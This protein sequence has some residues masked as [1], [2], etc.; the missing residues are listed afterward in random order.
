M[1]AS[2]SVP[3]LVRDTL[4]AEGAYDFGL[5]VVLR[6]PTDP[7]GT[8]ARASYRVEYRLE[9]VLPG[10]PKAARKE[11]YARDLAKAYELASQTFEEMQ[12]RAGGTYV[13]YHTDVP[14]GQVVWRWFDSPHPRWGV[15]YPD[16]VTSL[17][18]NWVTAPQVTIAWRAG[19]AP[20]P[21]ADVPIGAL[22][23]DHYNQALEHVRRARAHRTY[24]EVHGLV[25]QILKWAIANR[26]LRPQDQH[27]V[28]QLHLAREE[29]ATDD[30]GMTR[31]V[32]PEEIR[33]HHGSSDR[34]CRGATAVTRCPSRG[35][36]GAGAPASSAGGT[37]CGCNAWKPTASSTSTSPASGR[38]TKGRTRSSRPSCT[39]NRSSKPTISKGR[40]SGSRTGWCASTTSRGVSSKCRGAK[41]VGYRVAVDVELLG[42][43]HGHLQS[44]HLQRPVVVGTE[45]RCHTDAVR[46]VL[47]RAHRQ[48][49]GAAGDVGQQGSRRRPDLVA[50]LEPLVGDDA[51]FVDHDRPRIGQ[52]M[53]LVLHGLAEVGLLLDDVLVE[54][55]EP[56]DH[57]AAF[58]GEQ[59]I[60][61]TVA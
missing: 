19:G 28:A 46:L 49:R 30:G 38:I 35:R 14:F 39:K 15:H 54:K 60:G 55:P 40:G 47:V 50:R 5:G 7:R 53:V 11:R 6:A 61:H 57:H 29:E 4:A 8:G 51:V 2:V 3:K 45:P 59:R 9:P 56:L 52:P 21:I 18:R 48:D 58:V 22:T 26:Y 20:T 17:L 34:R 43:V 25:V 44:L 33:Q 37:P 42:D 41:P 27:T 13:E 12:Q 1:A 23:A 16:K 10:R 32:A 36:A 31:P 24:T